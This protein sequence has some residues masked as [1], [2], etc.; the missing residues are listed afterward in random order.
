MAIRAA[1]EY[2]HELQAGEML[3]GF[4]DE[5]LVIAAQLPRFQCRDIL[6]LVDAG[7][8]RQMCLSAFSISEEEVQM[9][10]CNTDGTTDA[11]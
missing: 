6:N 1:Y 4:V 2:A 9:Q 7:V 8:S 5:N 3:Q 11:R 10:Y